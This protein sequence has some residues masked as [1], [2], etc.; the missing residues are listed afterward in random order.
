MS[1]V[2]VRYLVDDID[3]AVDFYV[4]RLGFQ[5]QMR[6]G[7]GFAALVRGDLRLLLNAP[8]SG[9]AGQATPLPAGGR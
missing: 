1:K 8:G 9:G 4:Q 7:P 3:A 6:P 2:S 5:V